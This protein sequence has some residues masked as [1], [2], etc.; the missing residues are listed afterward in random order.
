MT[1]PA[2]TQADLNDLYT[3]RDISWVSSIRRHALMVPDRVAIVEGDETHTWCDFYTRI[4]SMAN[5]LAARGLSF[6]DRAMLCTG[7]SYRMLEFIL[8]THLCGALAVPVNFR[9][10]VGELVYAAT[11][12]RPCFILSD[13]LTIDT[14][15]EA[16]DKVPH[17]LRH[18][19]L[20]DA[21]PEGVFSYNELMAEESPDFLHPEIPSRTPAFIL[22]TS[23]TTGRPKGAVLTHQNLL[24][25]GVVCMSAYEG[26]RAEDAMMVSTPMFHI[27]ALGG[28]SALVV[29]GGKL[30]IQKSTSFDP[31]EILTSMETNGVSITFMVPTQWQ[32]LVK[33][34][35]E[36]DYDLSKLR[37]L[38][39]GAAPATVRLLTDMNE[40]FPTASAVAF[41]G[42]TE[43]SP[44]TCVLEARYAREKVGSIG[45]PV[46]Q[47]TARVVDEEMNDVPQGQVGEIVYR[48]SGMMVG[49]WNDPER[50]SQAMQGGWF[51]SGDL[52]YVDEEGFYYVSDRKKDMIISG[53]ENIY[54]AEVENVLSMHP[55]ISELAVVGKPHEKW[56]ETPVLFV[57]PNDGFDVPTVA[58]ITEFARNDLAKFKIPTEV[59]GVDA[60]PRNTA[61]KILKTELRERVGGT[62]HAIGE[63][64]NPPTT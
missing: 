7:N 3:A 51:H 57:V 38:G 1:F 5:A 19:T 45:R 58:D 34:A 60:M 56:G 44:V 50:T 53:G 62:P 47:V 39:W 27:G 28:M 48:G 61:G 14:V 26:I 31:D 9:S 52:V 23:G 2:T 11:D 18:I 4:C 49:Y 20:A 17:E 13:E 10:T 8:A 12:C 21:T 32:M 40:V 15:A 46:P 55:A 43:M 63:T 42:Q 54:S 25:N 22:Y 64:M 30:V 59:Y 41:F 37:I 6:G 16:C 36:K 24:S 35:R 29:C 33:Q